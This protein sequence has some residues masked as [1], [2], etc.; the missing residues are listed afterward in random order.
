[1]L[2]SLS[3]ADDKEVKFGKKNNKASFPISI[4]MTLLEFNDKSFS[5]F[6]TK[7]YLCN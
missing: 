7:K 2:Y 5:V 1:M 3:H 6:S 4:S